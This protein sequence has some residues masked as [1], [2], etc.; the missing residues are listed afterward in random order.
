MHRATV[1]A[2]TTSP[3]HHSTFAWSRPPSAYVKT[4]LTVPGPLNYH[5]A[6]TRWSPAALTPVTCR[7]PQA[8]VRPSR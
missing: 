7:I 6:V 5:Q 1:M 8:G 3:D 4:H 2:V